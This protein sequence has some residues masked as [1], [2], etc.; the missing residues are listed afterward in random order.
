MAPQ[1]RFLYA[2][3]S[4][5]VRWTRIRAALNPCRR[6]A[7][8]IRLCDYHS[9]ANTGGFHQRWEEEAR[10]RTEVV[11]QVG[12]EAD[13]V[14]IVVGLTEGTGIVV[15]GEEAQLVAVGDVDKPA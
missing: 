12:L 9:E 3:R 14:A 7:G 15:E 10:I 8:R 2:N 5:P 6:N 4:S 1:L 13:E 11:L